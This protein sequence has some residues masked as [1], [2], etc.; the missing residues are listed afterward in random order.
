MNHLRTHTG[1]RSFQC[2]LCPRAFARPDVLALHQ[3]VHTGIRDHRCTH[4]TRTFPSPSAL[5]KH[6]HMKHTAEMVSTPNLYECAQC[7]RRFMT[8]RG[9]AIHQ[10]IHNAFY[11]PHEC[12]QC[13]RRFATP[14][15]LQKHTQQVH[16]RVCTTG[17]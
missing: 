4:C 2:T 6:V 13:N 5:N 17:V 1:E 8:Q 7:A 14:T 15:R 10:R 12:Q 9:L 11:M 3:A 16:A